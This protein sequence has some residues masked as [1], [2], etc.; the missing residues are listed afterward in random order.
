MSGAFPADLSLVP[1][2]RRPLRLSDATVQR[3]FDTPIQASQTSS[4]HPRASIVVVTHNSVVFTRM[5][6][7]SVIANT[8]A[9][10]EYELIVVDNASTDG[11]VEFLRTLAER[12]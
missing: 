12:Q 2:S 1:L 5:C 7:A 4:V 11:T 3:V 10:P 9:D 6:L 8:P